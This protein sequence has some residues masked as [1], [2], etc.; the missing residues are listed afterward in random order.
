MEKFPTK[1]F[2]SQ[3]NLMVLR[4]LA[5]S[6][7]SSYLCLDVRTADGSPE[8]DVI[9]YAHFFVDSNGSAS[10]CWTLVRPD[11]GVTK[12]QSQLWG[13]FDEDL[14]ERPPL[15]VLA[16]WIEKTTKDSVIICPQ[17]SR[18]R[19][20]EFL[21]KLE[22]LN[23][24]TGSTK[25][26]SIIDIDL[27]LKMYQDSDPGRNSTPLAMA[28]K[29]SRPID[30]TS[31]VYRD[32][33]IAVGVLDKTLYE[34]GSRGI[35]RA[36][37]KFNPAANPEPKGDARTDNKV[38]P[39]PVD[40]A[41][42]SEK[43]MGKAAEDDRELNDEKVQ[44][45]R[46]QAWVEERVKNNDIFPV[47]DLNYL[48]TKLTQ[49]FP[50][51]GYNDKKKDLTSIG[52]ALSDQLKKGMLQPSRIIHKD[53]TAEVGPVVCGFLNDS[54]PTLTSVKKAVDEKTKRNV[55]YVLIRAC[56]MLL[57]HPQYSNITKKNVKNSSPQLK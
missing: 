20:Q 29:L 37:I 9:E 53:L 25:E 31:R 2:K 4:N 12:E 32:V 51:D 19:I 17:G 35:S 7:G 39:K 57:N 50:L 55:D 52:F 23:G 34:I 13:I 33:M 24:P 38:P 21:R 18:E 42:P 6:S 16:P 48:V 26:R 3:G 27:I 10:S 40:P 46:I 28:E 15:E 45:D 43:E 54:S 8:S 47:F 14:R 56:L 22:D 30:P 5:P 49:K 11:T 36:F 1:D 44:S 41:K